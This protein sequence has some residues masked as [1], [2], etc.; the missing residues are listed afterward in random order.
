MSEVT[1]MSVLSDTSDA[2]VLLSK[3]LKVRYYNLLNFEYLLLLE[4]DNQVLATQKGSD[5]L[6]G[7]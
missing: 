3:G 5:F 4:M 1:I 6:L 2:C 7:A